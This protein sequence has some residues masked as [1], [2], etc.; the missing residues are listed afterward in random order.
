MTAQPD[1]ETVKATIAGVFDRGADVYDQI[2]VDFFTPPARDL[3]TRAALR[4]GERVL[5]V[6]TGRGAV[7]FAAARAVGP[8][9]RVVGIDL[10]E[11]MAELTQA[12][13][14]ARG[15][16][17][18]T[19][20]KGDAE[21][22]DFP[23]ASFDAVLAGLV[24]FFLPDAGGALTRYRELLASEGRLAFTTFGKSDENHE[25]AMKAIGGFAADGAQR[26]PGSS[27][28]GSRDGIAEL[29]AQH[30]FAPRTIDE[31]TYESSFADPDHFISWVWSHGGRHALEAVP[32]DRL[33]DATAAARAAIEAA[34]T[35]AGD[36]V[37][38]T[39]IRFTT[40]RPQY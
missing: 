9:G 4:P 5:D 18:V 25:A 33:D 1:P 6:G 37:I 3:V 32:A 10:A 28:F 7:L 31:A 17:H 2:G 20:A 39:E 14:A 12:E 21:R 23:D 16:E 24:I 11:R 8:S 29:L 38:R 22:P 15:F 26:R 40:A 30:G 34:R 36:Y 19:V 35:P 27:P 13:A